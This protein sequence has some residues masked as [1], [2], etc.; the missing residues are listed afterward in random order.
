MA[1]PTTVASNGVAAAVEDDSFTKI[2]AVG[3]LKGGRVDVFANFASG[4]PAFVGTILGSG[5]YKC[6]D[7]TTDW[8]IASF[9]LVASNLGANA[10]MVFT[11][12]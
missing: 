11:F 8:T 9:S 12:S 2:Q 3:S 1:N 4:D 10:S 5:L 6:D 7:L